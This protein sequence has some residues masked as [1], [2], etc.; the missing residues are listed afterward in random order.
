MADLLRSLE[1]PEGFRYPHQFLRTVALGLI[2]L[3]PWWILEGDLL[4][5]RLAGVRTRYPA[6]TLVPFARRQD[7]DDVACFDQDTGKVVIIHDF[8]SPGWE[9]RAEVD[10]FYGW[11]RQ[12]IDDLVAFD[13]DS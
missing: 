4:R 8:A 1:L 7:T 2:D 3:E 6:R 13:A 12:A 10:D 9:Q 11:L 5:A